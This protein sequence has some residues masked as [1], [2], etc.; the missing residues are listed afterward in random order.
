[1]LTLGVCAY[2][3][4]SS[5]ALFSDTTLTGF[6]EEDRLIDEK[7]TRR[8]PEH[9]VDHLL[10]AAN[11][12][13]A[14]VDHVAYTFSSKLYP[15]GRAAAQRFTGP[16]ERR[17]RAIASYDAIAAQHR[18][19]LTGLR[20]RFPNACIH[21]VAHH[22]AHALCGV[23]TNQWITS[24]V[25]VADSIGEGSTTSIGRWDR[26]TRTLHIDALAM[27]THS[28]GYV[29]GAVTDHLGFRMRDEEGTVMALAAFGDP[30]RYRDV[31][32]RTFWPGERGAPV[33]SSRYLHQRVFGD[34][35]PRLTDAFVRETFARRRSHEPLTDSHRDLAAALQERTEDVLCAMAQ[36]LDGEH[37][38]VVGGVAANCVGIGR[39]RRAYPRTRFFVPPAPGDS[40][41]PIGAGAATLLEVTGSL[42][43]VPSTPYLGPDPELPT[44][45]QLFQRT[46]SRCAHHGDEQLAQVV[47]ER[48][49]A[50]QIIGVFR[51]RA[52]AGPRAL[53]NRSI[54]ANPAV[55]AI[56]RRLAHHVKK[57]ETFRPFAPIAIDDD[58]HRYV[59]L[60]GG[61]SPYMS[62]A[63]TATPTLEREA[64]VAVHHNGTTR[65]QTVPDGANPFIEAVLT[66]FKRRTGLG[67]LL[68]TSF[69]SKGHP[70][71]GRW[72][73]ALAY[74]DEM[75]L[76]A[77]V[78]GNHL[79]T[80][81]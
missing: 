34:S 60:D 79:V 69:N 72:T 17:A 45:A 65:M 71:A 4:D 61:Y 23:A 26:P 19:T 1:M 3:H 25:L 11:A 36:T 22:V 7:H 51:G 58:A 14:D 62:I 8:F 32:G 56:D 57:R 2:T 21:E 78:I 59:D 30:K 52:E 50:G 68:N 28:L 48:L 42:A 12:D 29:Y 16:A 70:T 77:V 9:A 54:L 44:T 67:L 27:D 18:R 6:L 5:A 15:A 55:E 81:R 41:T 49:A 47:A 24:D 37:A 31:V 35:G 33:V 20:H 13:A 43:D 38:T 76:D 75:D 39:L 74:L 10:R 64:P 66:H 63:L 53:G 80:R 40:G 73:A 46:A